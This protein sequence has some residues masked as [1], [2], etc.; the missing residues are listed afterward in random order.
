[1]KMVRVVSLL[2]SGFFAGTVVADAMSVDLMAA[3][4]RARYAIRPEGV[5][6]TPTATSYAQR[7]GVRFEAPGASVT[8]RKAR[9]D[10]AEP[11]S[12][13]LDAW[14][15]EGSLMTTGVPF[16]S[17]TAEQVDYAYGDITEWWK[18]SG[19]GLEHG[20]D[21]QRRPAGNRSR[22]L[23]LQMRIGKSWTAKPMGPGLLLEGARG[24]QLSYD[25]LIARDANG[26][27]VNGRLAPTSSGFAL[28]LDDANAVYPLTVDPIITNLQAKLDGITAGEAWALFGSSVSVSGNTVAVGSPYDDMPGAANAGSVYVFVRDGT[29]WTHQARLTV[30]D[31][32]TDDYF[33]AAVSVSGDTILVG[34]WSDDNAGSSPGSAYVFVRSGTTW[35]QQTQLTATGTSGNVYYGW[36]VALSGDTAVVGAYGN[37]TPTGARAGTAYVYVRS[38]T[39][40]TQQANLAAADSEDADQFGYSVSVSGDTILVGAHQSHLFGPVGYKGAAHVFTRSGTTW[41]EQAKLVAPDGAAMDRFGYSVSIHG[42]T[43]VVGSTFDDIPGVPDA[44]SVHVFVR[45]GTSWSQQAHLLAADAGYKDAFGSSV[46]ISGD[47]IL[48]GAFTDDTA[49]GLGVGSAYVFVRSGAS[50]S[51]QAQILSA[52]GIPQDQFGTSVSVDGDTAV[53]GEPGDETTAGPDAGSTTVFVRKGT[54]WT[55]EAR[56]VAMDANANERAGWSVAMNG[57]TA[58]V[59]AYQKDAAG[60]ILAGGVYVFV[61]NGTSWTQQAELQASDGLERDALG[62]SVAISGDT[63]VAGAYLDD[64]PAG[65]DA[66]SAYVFVRNGTTWTQQAKLLASNGAFIG[67]FG[68]SVS[69]SGDTIVVGAATSV[70]VVNGPDEGSAHVFVRNGTIWT[71]QAQLVP[72]DPAASGMFASSISLSG[73]TV[74]VGAATTHTFAGTKTGT[75]HVFVRTGTSWTQ[76]AQLLSSDAA[77]GDQFGES[78]SIDGDTILVGAWGVS[79]IAGTDAG[80]AYV[81]VRNGTSWTQQAQLLALDGA[82]NDFFGDSVVVNGDTVVV[83]APYDNT[84]GGTDAGSAYL[85]IRNGAIWTQQAKLHAADGA[86]GD[87]FGNSVALSGDTVL[88]G[89]PYDDTAGGSDAGSAHVFAIGSPAGITVAP[90]S[91]LIT[92]ES[93]GTATFT[94]VLDSQPTAPVT[95]AVASSDL[96]EG[97]A[98]PAAVTFTSGN[99]NVPRTVTVTGVDDLFMDGNI[100]YTILT[101]PAVSVDLHYAGLNA[102]DVSVTNNDNDTS[103]IAVSSSANPSNV[104]QPVTLT[105][106]VTAISGTPTGT[107]TFL[108]GATTLA[109]VALAGGVA[110]YTTSALPGGTHAITATYDGNGTYAASSGTVSQVVSTGSTIAFQPTTYWQNEGAGAVIVTVGRTGGDTSGPASVDYATTGGTASAGARFAPVIGTLNFAAGQTTKTIPV[111]LIDETAI[112]GN[113]TF[114]LTLTNAN[115]AVLGAAT[116]TINVVDDDD[117]PSDFSFPLDGKADIVWRNDATGATKVW[118]MNGTSFV[119]S[120]DLVQLGGNWKLQGAAD[121]NADGTAD[122][123]YRNSVDYSMVVWYMNGTGI[124]STAPVAS[125]PDP[126]WKIAAMGDMNG[127]G[128]PDLLWR[129]T[130]FSLAIWVM[131]DNALVSANYLPTVNDNNWQVKGLGDF[132]RD[133]QTDIVWRNTL[134]SVTAV[135][136][137]APGGMTLGSAA[138]MTTVGAPWDIVGVGD[139]NGDGDSDLIWQASTTRTL[140]VWL[141]DQTNRTSIVVAPTNDDPNWKFMAPR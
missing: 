92:T 106:L 108:N 89:A 65:F 127:D 6:R 38:G 102:A 67:K 52:A 71:H 96:T 123:L 135:W 84:P 27:E 45:S 7:L 32:K 58:V 68:Y 16:R 74:V 50:W 114:N 54:S 128:Y 35:T 118:T 5:E 64:T 10:D 46:S 133:G 66:G 88:V 77:T 139:M 105:A 91:G 117:V 26:R 62:Y 98:L 3:V 116:A 110:T 83:G 56:L 57:D 4:Q 61:R 124:L 2:L 73:N 44:G 122:L 28:I 75:A 111:S 107:V 40:W 120:A 8:L 125:V 21:V 72:P 119:S 95:I 112:Q 20:F 31:G 53:I 137:M 138:I 23:V 11:L 39:V 55:Q 47:T 1:M 129:H 78:V 130:N 115:A 51:Q 81:F 14:G 134:H 34:A 49:D 94:I 36:S 70:K 18:N 141:M 87:K 22:P 126:N 90:A 37:T 24:E 100:G 86:A 13:K 140:A 76:R 69:V 60:G 29:T 101:L 85:F 12:M 30:P 113:Q 109:T 63:V 136:L 121:F 79:T 41:T 99:Y 25:K 80:S 131:R 43:A 15:V 19:A 42:E 93:G 17:A 132:N 97:I 33:G 104:G 48:V 9:A 103:A 59:G 82:T